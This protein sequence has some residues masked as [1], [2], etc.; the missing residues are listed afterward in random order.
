MHCVCLTGWYCLL[1]GLLYVVFAHPLICSSETTCY[2]E[3]QVLNN[4]VLGGPGLYY[5]VSN[6]KGRE[7]MMLGK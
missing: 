2:A 7:S 3:H 5:I 1:Q 4:E 6:I